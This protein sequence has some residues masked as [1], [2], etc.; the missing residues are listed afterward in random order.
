MLLAQSEADL[1]TKIATVD[2]QVAQ[3]TKDTDFNP[4]RFVIPQKSNKTPFKGTKSS[5]ACVN[6]A[7]VLKTPKKKTLTI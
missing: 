4:F 6:C 1:A 2:D 3:R 7:N 5:N